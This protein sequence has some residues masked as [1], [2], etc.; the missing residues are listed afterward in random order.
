MSNK[1]S[2]K[3]F[4]RALTEAD[5]SSNFNDALSYLDTDVLWG[6]AIQ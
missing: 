2:V 1:P 4:Y 5:A 6:A 3:N